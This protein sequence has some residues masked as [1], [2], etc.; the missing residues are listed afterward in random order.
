MVNKSIK[1]VICGEKNSGKTC[2][3]L[4]AIY[5]IN[6]V[7]KDGQLFLPTVEDSFWAEVEIENERKVRVR[8]FDTQGLT[9]EN[10]SLPKFLYSIADAYLLVYDVTTPSSY[11]LMKKLRSDIDSKKEKRDA[12]LVTLGTKCDIPNSRKIQFH[13]AQKW[14]SD[15]KV[16]LFEVS[17]VEKS[18]LI[19]PICTIVSKATQLPVKSS[20]FS[21][22]ASLKKP[23]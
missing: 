11:E 3:L 16:R 14:A 15:E 21:L 8:F 4:Q 10:I 6:A 20:T 23:R 22:P 5:N 1:V 12:P 7:G 13:E 18:S 17:A 9:S 2:L 19:D